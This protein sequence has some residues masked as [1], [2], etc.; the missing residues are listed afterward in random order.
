MGDKKRKLITIDC[1]TDP[2]LYGR[3]PAP[4]VWGAYDGRE[5]RVFETG[6]ELV[7]WLRPQHCVV[8]AHNGGRFD[9]LFLQ[10]YLEPW[11]SIRMINGRMAAFKIGE[12]IF[13]DSFLILPTALKNYKKGEISYSL[14]EKEERDKPE[15][16]AKI[17]EYLRLDCLYLFELVEGFRKTY[18]AG[19]TLATSAMTFFRKQGEGTEIPKTTKAHYGLFKDFYFGGRVSCFE[20]GVLEGDFRAYD[21]NSAYPFAMLSEHFWGETWEGWTGILPPK[22]LEQSFIRLRCRS[23]GAFCV[24]DKMGLAF[25]EDGEIREFNVTGWEYKAAK[26]TG[27]L[28]EVE[29]LQAYSPLETINFKDYV[30][31][32]YGKKQ[33]ADPKSA[34]YL[35]FKLFLNSLYGKLSADPSRYKNYF[36]IPAQDVPTLE[37]GG[38]K[39]F[40]GFALESF[41]GSENQLALVGKPLEEGE[42]RFYNVATGASI[43]GFVRALLWRALVKAKRPLYCDTDGILAGG[44]KVPMGKEI[45]G[46]KEE[47]RGKKVGIAGK[48]L[49][50]ITDGAPWTGWKDG[51]PPKG[52]KIASKGVRL[53]GPEIFKV[54]SG[55]RLRY[56]KESP[57]MS[58]KMG[59]KFINREIR[60]TAG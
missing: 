28:K 12:A 44:L 13:R 59:A 14:M 60:K 36:V 18:G 4:F 42:Q 35:Y 24:R 55:E 26:E 19:L 37:R 52:W 3:V 45:G 10:D 53:T 15:V 2:F 32:F 23:M 11:N 22:R 7:E 9:F 58:L 8:Y 41:I 25:P 21:L 31:Y 20:T 33:E 49:Y 40:D 30:G 43:T 29:I 46:W 34:D 57:S 5:F 39:G 1:E 54:A 48:K 38:L 27:Y 16:R 17:L 6:K 56:Y 50:A 51:R 47:F